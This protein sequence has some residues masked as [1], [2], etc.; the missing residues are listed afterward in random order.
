MSIWSKLVSTHLA[1]LEE[2]CGDDVIESMLMESGIKR[3]NDGNL[4]AESFTELNRYLDTL[5]S[6]LGDLYRNRAEQIFSEYIER[7]VEQSQPNHSE[8]EKQLALKLKQQMQLTERLESR[9]KDLI[10]AKESAE[11]ASRAKSVFLA[12]MSHE[13]RTPMNGVI[14]SVQLLQETA[15][16]SE[17]EEL[18]DLISVS[19]GSLLNII[20]D[21]LDLSKI[22]SGHMSLHIEAFNMHQLVMDVCELNRSLAETKKVNLTFTI[23]EGTPQYLLG[24]PLRVRQVIMNLV[25]NA[26]KFTAEGRVDINVGYDKIDQER[27]NIIFEVNDTGI[28]I[29]RDRIDKI[30]ESFQQAD[31]GIGR[32]YG[33]TGLGLTICKSLTELMDGYLEVD[34]EPHKGASFIVTLPMRCTEAVE[35]EVGN[36]SL[37]GKNYNKSVLVAED[38]P[39][40]QQVAK[41]MLEKLGLEVELVFDGREAIKAANGKRYDLIILDIEMPVLN[42]VDACVNILAGEGQN[43][44]TPIIAMTASVL[45]QDQARIT[46]A[47]MIGI[48]GKPVRMDQ[49]V[50]QLDKVFDNDKRP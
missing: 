11:V 40:N 6:Y 1:A 5:E 32:E 16:T 34:S 36:G 39:V 26:I 7:S 38:N 4:V 27:F 18:L 28:G 35:Y 24:D 17:Q 31:T 15:L 33:G 8:I 49:L 23:E 25:T 21:I 3:D 50:A 42:G 14:A 20:N 12:S 2:S 41:K 37:T 44:S 45:E 29:P 43:C 30:F 47:G 9:N 46:D 48:V 10:H 13:I 22:E 19:S